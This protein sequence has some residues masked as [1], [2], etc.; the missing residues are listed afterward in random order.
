[1]YWGWQMSSWMYRYFD[2]TLRYDSQKSVSVKANETLYGIYVFR[3]A[4]SWLSR[5]FLR[6]TFVTAF[7]CSGSTQRTKFCVPFLLNKCKCNCIFAARTR[8]F[9]CSNLFR[10]FF[11]FLRFL[12]SFAFFFHRVACNYRHGSL[13]CLEGLAS[14]PIDVQTKCC[15]L[16]DVSLED[17]ETGNYPRPECQAVQNFMINYDTIASGSDG[18]VG[19]KGKLN[20]KGPEAVHLPQRWHQWMKE[21]VPIFKSLCY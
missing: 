1:M 5:N 12:P 15:S 3:R 13:Q 10:C 4:V 17:V 16:G 21:T 2:Q 9:A 11:F 6:I 19:T 14:T 8:L 20:W 7:I 18:L